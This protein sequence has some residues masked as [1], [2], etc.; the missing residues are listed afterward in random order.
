MR[1]AASAIGVDGTAGVHS[2]HQLLGARPNPFHP[3]TALP[4][5]LAGEARVKVRV[6]DASGRIVASLGDRVLT[7]GHHEVDWNGFD[8]DGRAVSSGGYFYALEV[9]RERVDSRR[10]SLLR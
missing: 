1:A 9:D 7:T 5:V 2:P 3:N 10:M 6:Y 4:F 8:D